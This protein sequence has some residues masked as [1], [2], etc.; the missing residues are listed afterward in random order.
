MA[1]NRAAL[2]L[3]WQGGPSPGATIALAPLGAGF[4]GCSGSQ[5]DARGQWGGRDPGSQPGGTGAWR[6]HPAA[7][8]RPG[9]GGRMGLVGWGYSSPKQIHSKCFWG[10]E[11]A[12]SGMP[13]QK[14]G[15]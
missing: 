12:G 2:S 6:Q 7:G 13:S 10:R 11:A 5:E 9:E 4:Q 1:K 3:G 15:N 14:W 8:L